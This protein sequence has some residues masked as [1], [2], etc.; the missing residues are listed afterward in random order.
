[1]RVL[2]RADKPLSILANLI[3]NIKFAR[4]TKR[5]AQITIEQLLQEFP[6]VALLGPRQVGKTTLAQQVA[7]TLTPTPLYIDLENPSKQIMLSDPEGYFELH[8]GRLIILDEIQ[9]LPELFSLLRGVIDRRRKEGFRHVQF[10]ML[11]SASSKLLKQSS[12]T[13]ADRIAYKELTG[14]LLFEITNKKKLNELWLRGGF[15]DSFLANNNTASL[16]WRQHFISTYLERDVP[17]LGPNVPAVTLRKLWTMLAHQ[18]GAQLNL[19]KL[20]ASLGFAVPTIK[21]YIALLEDLLLIRSL[22]PW[23]S[24]IGKLLVKTPKVYIRDSGLTH[25]LL[26]ITTIDDLLSH[27]VAGTS[28]EGFIIENII[29]SLPAGITYW[30]YQTAAGA[31]IDLVLEKGNDKIFAI[32]IKRSLTPAISKGFYIGCEDIKAT[33]R[34]VVYPGPDRFLMGKGVEAI[35]LEALV[36][37]AQ[38]M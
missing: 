16:R 26:N 2:N 36:K 37:K 20:A 28:W 32:E 31:E 25:A 6:V 13:L 23:H 27:P 14:L 1:M 5:Y 17:Q 7:S 15:P 9:K 38:K 3:L 21:R 35:P 33:D 30:F 11:G 8:K 18:Q 34:F 12:E 24:N 22:H 10:L 19:S 29:A 4:M